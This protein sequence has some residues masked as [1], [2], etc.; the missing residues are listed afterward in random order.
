LKDSAFFVDFSFVKLNLTQNDLLEF[1]L[2]PPYIPTV[3]KITD[4][5]K[6]K[7][8]YI[9]KLNQVKLSN[10]RELL[11][12]QYFHLTMMMRKK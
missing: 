10:I 4:N 12:I 8:K 1:K 7:M 11:R 6:N 2:I 3:S 5:L 9:E